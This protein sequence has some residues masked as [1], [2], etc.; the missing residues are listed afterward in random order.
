MR[1]LGP[2]R[3][4]HHYK[5]LRDEQLTDPHHYNIFPNCSVTFGADT[6]LLQRMRPHPT[7]PE[8]CRF[9]HWNYVSQASIEHG[10]FRNSDGRTEFRGDAEIT[11]VEY[12]KQSMGTIA[13]QDIGITTGQ[14]LGLRSRGYRGANLADQESRIARF[15][16][17]IDQYLE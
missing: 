17:V 1:I 11:E 14:Q 4:Y 6:V 7:D 15:H 2:E 3:G 16:A 8:R 12:G 5:R 13:D 10:L 9:D